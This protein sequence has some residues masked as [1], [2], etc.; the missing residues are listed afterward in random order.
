ML[1]E[2]YKCELNVPCGKF[3]LDIVVHINNINIDIEYDG[4]YWHK[5]SKDMDNF[6]NKIVNK[7]GYKILR[8]RSRAKIPDIKIIENAIEELSNTN[9]NIAI[10][11]LDDWKG[12]TS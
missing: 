8:I 12:Y 9:K 6:R 11:T 2:K 5:D 3:F 7:N 1:S 4:W 10:I